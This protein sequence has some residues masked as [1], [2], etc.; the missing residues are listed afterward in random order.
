MSL[1]TVPVFKDRGFLLRHSQSIMDFY[2]PVCID[3]ESGGFF[4]YF[5]DDG[6]VYDSSTRHLVSSTRFIF[7]Y[8]M[9]LIHLKND[10]YLNEIR[11]GIDFLRNSHLNQETGGYAWTLKDGVIA[12]SSNYCYGLAFVLLAYSSAYTAGISEAQT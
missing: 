5:R 6:S 8:S 7:N 4:H 9:A 12:D 2:H 3:K 1:S 10:E 11:H